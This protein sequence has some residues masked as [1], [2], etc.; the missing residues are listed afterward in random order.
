[1]TARN[2]VSRIIFLI[3]FLMLVPDALSASR[4]ISVQLRASESKNAELVG[5]IRMYSESYALVVGIDEYTQ[6]WPKLS[7]AVKDAELIAEALEEKGFEVDLH[8]NLDSAELMQ[9]FK[10]FFILKGE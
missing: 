10:R 2:M 4:G 8:T 5:E 3:A 1:M 7:N 9:V 6:G